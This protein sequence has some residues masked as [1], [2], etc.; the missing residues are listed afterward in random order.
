MIPFYG[1]VCVPAS[2]LVGFQQPGQYLQLFFW[3]ETSL[4]LLALLGTHCGYGSMKHI[5][6]GWLKCNLNSRVPSWKYIKATLH[7]MWPKMELG[8]LPFLFLL[9]LLPVLEPS[10]S[11][12]TSSTTLSW[13]GQIRSDHGNVSLINHLH[14]KP[15]LRVC[16]WDSWPKAVFNT[17]FLYKHIHTEL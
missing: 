9:L 13:S 15:P 17:V 12:P 10:P 2:T 8:F 7:E 6:R 5:R 3:K 14:A 11:S 16:L 4:R 1:F